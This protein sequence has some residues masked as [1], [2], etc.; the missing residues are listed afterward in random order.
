M[1]TPEIKIVGAGLLGTSLGLALK[2][3]GITAQLADQSKANLRLAIEYGAGVEA[4]SEPD[5][6]VVCVPPD[7]TA[8]VVVR[9]LEAHPDATVTDVAST[10]LQIQNQVI[11]LTDE[12]HRYIGSHPMAGREKGGPGKAR[13]D[14]FFARPWV[15]AKRDQ[16]D[17]TRVE[18]IRDLA[19]RLGALPQLMGAA[20]HDAAVALISHLPQLAASAIAARLVGANP[21]FLALSGQGLRDTTRIAAS[22]PELWMQI[23][24]Q[25]ASE[26]A[27]L[28]A[29]VRDDLDRLH[30]SLSDPEAPGSLAA[31]HKLLEAGNQGVSQIPGKHG[32]KFTNY[33]QVTV[34]IDDS[35]GALATLFTFIGEIGVNLEDMKLEHSPGAAIGLVEL[36][37]VPE[38]L[39]RLTSALT[40]N[41]WRL[42]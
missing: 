17:S 2:N 16:V 37:V 36:Q 22:D 31:L 30:N 10:K 21:D 6:I 5:L 33:E 20:D 34:I 4:H 18:Q 24:Q 8:E 39:Q 14:L 9:E 15:I 28:I 27:P 26:L 38:V 40:E 1:K 29:E 25:N 41:G 7:M 32:G 19:L 13:A 3:H 42:V 23:L 35:P 11:A 12:H